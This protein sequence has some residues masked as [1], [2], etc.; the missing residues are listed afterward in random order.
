MGT[1]A[2]E[3]LRSPSGSAYCLTADP[4]GVSVYASFCA[5]PARLDD[6]Q[7]RW[8]IEPDATIRP[9]NAQWRRSAEQADD[10]PALCL[11]NGNPLGEI[12]STAV[13]L[14]ECDGSVVQHWAYHG[15]VRY[16]TRILCMHSY[17]FGLLEK[18]AKSFVGHAVLAL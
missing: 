3:Q 18:L 16:N 15:S 9:V 2:T 11:T 5:S 12:P 8:T 6:V 1:I 7:Q 13:F 14:K 17:A 4:N 10:A